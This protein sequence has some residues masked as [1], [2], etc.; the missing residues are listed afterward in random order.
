MLLLIGVPLWLGL[1][2]WAIRAMIQANERKRALEAAAVAAIEAERR[3]KSEARRLEIIEAEANRTCPICAER[4]KRAA[5][6]CRYCGHQL[7]KPVAKA[8]GGWPQLVGP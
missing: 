3:A 2:I 1:V 5:Q 4:V 8:P 6:V 7:P